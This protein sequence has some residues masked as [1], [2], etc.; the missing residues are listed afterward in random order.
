MTSIENLKKA[1]SLLQE[2]EMD[3]GTDFRDIVYELARSNPGTLL[4]VVDTLKN[5]WIELVREELKNERK[6]QAIK[7]YR[8]QTGLGLKESKEAVESMPEY[9]ELRQRQNLVRGR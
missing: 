4:A 1:I 2:L 3:P 5:S 8:E 6:I 9:D 7:I